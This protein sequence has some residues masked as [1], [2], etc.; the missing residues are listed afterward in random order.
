M[1]AAFH[2]NIGRDFQFVGIACM[3]KR[4]LQ[5]IGGMRAEQVAGELELRRCKT[6]SEP[7]RVQLLHQRYQPRRAQ[8][9]R[10]DHQPAEGAAGVGAQ[11]GAS[12]HHLRGGGAYGYQLLPVQHH[13]GRILKPPLGMIIQKPA[14]L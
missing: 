10:R 3:I 4:I 9:R 12:P 8:Q 6:L 14:R 7:V 13:Q 1:G 11:H 2:G 5:H